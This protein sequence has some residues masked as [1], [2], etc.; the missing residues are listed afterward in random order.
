[1]VLYL[2]AVPACATGEEA[3]SIAMILLEIQESKPVT[4]P[5]QIFATDLSEK[6]INKARMGIYTQQELETV[7]P[8]RIQRFFVKAEAGFRVNKAVREMCVFAPHNILR[9]P[10]F[11]RLDF[12]SCCNLFIYFDNPAQK[13][14]L[15]TFHY[16]LNDDGFLMLGKSENISYSANLFTDYNKKYKIFSRKVNSG[17]RTLTPLLPRYA[18]QPFYENNIAVTNKIKR[19]TT[20]PVNHN[21]LDNAIDAV[22][23]AEFMPASVVINH[24]LEIVQFRG[25]TDLFLTHPKGRATFNILKMAR[26]EIA[27][28]HFESHKNKSALSQKRH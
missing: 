23:V 6:A 2:A 12:I 21:G 7:S 17:N 11:S 20:I 22:L 4:T 3:Y 10:P 9:D 8:K 13:K 14:T 24:Q 15:N 28:C 16:A 25:T 5:I 19:K 18:Q 26:P 27:Q 1:M